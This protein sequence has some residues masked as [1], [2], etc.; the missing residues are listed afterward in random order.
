MPLA[1]V[2]VQDCIWQGACVQ[3]DLY[4]PTILKKKSVSP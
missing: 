3:L 2:L 1:P 4:T